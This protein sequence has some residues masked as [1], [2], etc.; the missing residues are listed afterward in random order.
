M[1]FSKLFFISCFILLGGISQSAFGT[2]KERQIA[3]DFFYKNSK[4]HFIAHFVDV[5]D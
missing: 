5:P 1:N 3:E 4:D 2:E